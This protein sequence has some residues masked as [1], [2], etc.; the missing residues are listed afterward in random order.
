MTVASHKK[1]KHHVLMSSGKK[2]PASGGKSIQ[3]NT[4]YGISF[5]DKGRPQL[6]SSTE[7]E[8]SVAAE[9]DATVMEQSANHHP[10]Q[11]PTGQVVRH[12]KKGGVVNNNFLVDGGWQT[13]QAS[14][15]TPTD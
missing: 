10:A 11:Y 5:K 8:K 4:V 12:P 14:N 6:I 1:G 9:S 2:D 13:R 7:F 3:H 15:R